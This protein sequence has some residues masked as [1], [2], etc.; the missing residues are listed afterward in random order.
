MKIKKKIIPWNKGINMWKGKKHPRG[1]LNKKN[2]WG[3]H[4]EE[5]KI[6]ISKSKTGVP[7]LKMKG[8]KKS[9]AHKNK[10]SK[11]IIKHY[12]RKCLICKKIFKPRTNKHKLCSKECMGIYN[13]G[14][15]NFLWKGG[16]SF[17]I[18]PK[19]WQKIRNIIRRRD[20][21]TCMICGIKE[22]YLKQKLCVHHL[23]ENKQNIQKNNLISLCRQCHTRIHRRKK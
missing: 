17:E 9:E 3:Y 15:N 7:N 4:S 14:E 22:Q 21:H 23:D 16:K 8:I 2:K 1:M 20:N 6:K 13:S 12:P 18:Y 19:E 5:T 10:I 11:S